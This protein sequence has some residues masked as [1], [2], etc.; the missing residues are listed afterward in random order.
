MSRAEKACSSVRSAASALSG[1]RVKRAQHKDVD[2]VVA[3]DEEPAAEHAAQTKRFEERIN[4]Y[5]PVIGGS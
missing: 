4:V 3:V 5:K 2:D 1:G